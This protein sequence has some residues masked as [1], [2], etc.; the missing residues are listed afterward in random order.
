[1]ASLL[2]VSNLEMAMRVTGHSHGMPLTRLAI[3]EPTVLT[4]HSRSNQDPE[5]QVVMDAKA[6]YDAL[7]SEQQNQ[8]D[9]RAA[10]ECSLI[11]EDLA[12]VGSRPRW[13]PHDKNP[14]DALTKVDGAHFTPMAKLLKTSSFC[15]KE[16]AEEL[17]RR[18]PEL[19]RG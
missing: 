12:I 11:K 19:A 6:L 15:I 3:E 4:K 16:E 13:V 2:K 10:L 8:D 5:A 9:E 17:S 14:A 18:R 7:L 1:M